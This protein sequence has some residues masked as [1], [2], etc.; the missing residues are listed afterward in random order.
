[1]NHFKTRLGALGVALLAGA[2]AFAVPP[3]NF[4]GYFSGYYAPANWTSQVYGNPSFQNT[5]FVYTGGVPESLEIDGAVNSLGQI[6]TPNL[7]ISTIDYTIV[8]SGTGLQ[9]VTFNYSFSGLAIG[10]YD[11][12]SLLYDGAVVASLS[13]LLNSTQQTYFNNTT[14]QG[15]HTFGFRVNSNNDSLADTLIISA[16]PEPSAIALLGLG[17]SALL[18]RLRRRQS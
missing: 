15:G 11:S 9:Q 7:P 10:G 12:A 5:A 18:W 17:G 4:S 6:G 8:L 13:T 14:F 16:V 1:M 2:S 3:A